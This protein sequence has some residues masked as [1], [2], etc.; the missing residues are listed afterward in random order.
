MSLQIKRRPK[1][2]DKS[3]TALKAE[4]KKQVRFLFY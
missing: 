2:D 3:L 4:K 1:F